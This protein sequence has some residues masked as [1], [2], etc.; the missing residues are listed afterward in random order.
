[1]IDQ[2][3]IKKFVKDVEVGDMIDLEDDPY[4]DPEGNVE[5]TFAFAGV[6][7]VEKQ[8]VDCIVLHTTQGSFGFPPDHLIEWKEKTF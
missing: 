2:G 6:D 3:T 8:D 5:F 7:E 4:A 1:M